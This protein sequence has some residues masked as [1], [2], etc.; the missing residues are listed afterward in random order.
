MLLSEFSMQ[1]KPHA[2]VAKAAKLQAANVIGRPDFH[3]L[4]DELFSRAIFAKTFALGGLRVSR[5]CFR[6]INRND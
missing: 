1:K 5:L 3:S 4:F 2:K 6:L